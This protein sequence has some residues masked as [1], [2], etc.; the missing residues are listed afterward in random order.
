MD[1]FIFISLCILLWL[2]PL[3]FGGNI[4]WAVFGL[5]VA[6][7]FLFLV[8]LI[9][10]LKPR[11]LV[12]PVVHRNRFRPV[13]FLTGLFFLLALAQILPWPESLVR[14]LSPVAWSWRQSLAQMGLF[15]AAEFRAQAF[16]LSPWASAYELVRYLSYTAFVFLLSGTL[17]SRSRIKALTLTLVSAGVFQ[18]LYGL[19]EFFGGTNRIFTW[20]NRYYSGSAFGTFIN[21]DHYSAFLEMLFPLSLGYFLVRAEF[22]SLKPGLSWRQ[23]IVRFGQEQV[24]KS[25]LFIIPPLIIGL[26]LFFSRC[27]SGI[28]IFIVT[29]FLTLLL[30][31]LTSISGR[32]KTEK[33]LV[34]AVVLLVL[35]GVVLVGI[36]PVLERFTQ[37]GFFDQNRLLFYRYTLDLVS[38]YPLTGCGLGTYV[39]AINHYLS[40]D[41]NVILSHAHNDYL[42][43]LAEAGLVGGLALVLAAILGFALALSGWL[44]SRDP[45]AKGVGLGA[46][47]G[48]F[49][50]LFHSLTDFSL[51]MPGNALVWLSL[52]VLAV[53]A[54]VILEKREEP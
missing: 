39:Q 41:F 34:R 26:G 23:K 27:R 47:M 7:W 16:S 50:L 3:P 19:S 10:P 1:S 32:H 4:E 6:V 25:L 40:K 2:L 37:G 44:K 14:T 8:Y 35:L 43:M 53:R 30:L 49:A 28:I 12:V 11:D 48:V 17:T 20:V 24:Q 46:L 36:G 15:S 45:L 51:R 38:D 29:F 31:S 21:R 22:F 13:Y 9:S 54:P 33:R 18:S 52:F 42:E 5:E